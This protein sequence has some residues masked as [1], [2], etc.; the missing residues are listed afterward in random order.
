MQAESDLSATATANEAYDFL[1][2]RYEESKLT[3]VV[4]RNRILILSLKMFINDL[5]ISII[6]W[7]I[8]TQLPTPPPII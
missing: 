7:I 4:V 3:V 8:L 1:S 5:F 6:Y 2:I